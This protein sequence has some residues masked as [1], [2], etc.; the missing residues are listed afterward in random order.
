ML[1]YAQNYEF[2][3]GTI[4]FNENIP[5]LIFLLVAPRWPLLDTNLLK[6]LVRYCSVP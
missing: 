6:Q 5:L 4:F 1:Y 3:M 2:S